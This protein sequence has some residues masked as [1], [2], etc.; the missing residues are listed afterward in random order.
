[1]WVKTV[2]LPRYIR[3]FIWNRK[4]KHEFLCQEEEVKLRLI[5]LRKCICGVISHPYHNKLDV[6]ERG[7]RVQGAEAPVAG[8]GAR[9]LPG[10]QG[11]SPFRG[12]LCRLSRYN[13]V[14]FYCRFAGRVRALSLPISDKNYYQF[15]SFNF[16]IYKNMFKLLL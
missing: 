2:W 13:R 3:Y 16:D 8:L 1:M 6:A 7:K 10:V 4:R 11:R 14:Q 12:F 9:S 5:V 15:V